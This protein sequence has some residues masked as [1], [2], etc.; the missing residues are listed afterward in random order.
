[1]HKGSGMLNT[2]KRISWGSV[3][4][5]V[6]IAIVIQ[7][8]LSLLGI[9]IG[10]ST[11]D[12][13]T[14][15]NPMAGLGTGTAIWYAFSSLIALFAGGWIAGRLAQTPR[16]FDG[17]IHGLLAWSLV[18]LLTFYFLT[19]T[20]GSVIGGVGRLVGNTLGTVGNMAGKGIQAAA[21]AVQDALK[22]Q[23]IDLSSLKEEA[24]TLLRQTGKSALQP[25]A[26][27]KQV[28][29]AGNEVRNSAGNAGEIRNRRTMK[30]AA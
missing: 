17:I 30:S 21:P 15:A 7:L 6:L 4:A 18:T 3:F 19:T 22:D 13:M 14:E 26:L 20:I 10:L 28:D 5:G 12:P 27:S 29:A 16:L 1:M 23:G 11:V 24:T 25:E 9:G 2:V 8:A